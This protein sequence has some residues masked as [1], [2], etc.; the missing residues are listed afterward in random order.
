MCT[1]VYTCICIY[2]HIYTIAYLPVC[3]YVGV[4]CGAHQCGKDRGSGVRNRDGTEAHE[5]HYLHVSDQGTQQ[6]E[7]RVRGA[8]HGSHWCMYIYLAYSVSCAYTCICARTSY[9][10]ARI[11]VQ[12]HVLHGHITMYPWPTCM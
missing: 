11:Y 5:P 3:L 2:I 12:T 4:C 8:V 9:I 6:S 7:V 1:Y 10:Y